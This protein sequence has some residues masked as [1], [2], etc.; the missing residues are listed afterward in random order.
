MYLNYQNVLLSA[1]LISRVILGL[2]IAP[3][4][5]GAGK[6]ILY[7]PIATG[8][9]IQIQKPAFKGGGEEVPT[10][11]RGPHQPQVTCYL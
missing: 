5:A 4:F 8:Y 1:W 2:Y 11:Q 6:T 7:P 9:I 10:R 3:W